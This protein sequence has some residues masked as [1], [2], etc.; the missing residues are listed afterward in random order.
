MINKSQA[1]SQLHSLRHTGFFEKLAHFA[2]LH[3]IP[4]EYFF[5]IASRETNCQNILG[6]F[7]H[8]EFHGVGIVQIDIQHDIARIA[9]DTG[10]FKTNPGPLLDFGAKMLANNIAAAKAAF[11]TLQAP[12]HLKIAAS[13][14]N[15]GIGRAIDGSKHGDSDLAT[16]GKDYGHD[17]MVRK[18]LFEE[19]IIEGN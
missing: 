19:L 6:D 14:Y 9:R 17:V 3:G 8:G 15:C 16:T 10:S 2:E 1:L 4:S 18:A 11:P 12:Q 13:G 5:A 7:A